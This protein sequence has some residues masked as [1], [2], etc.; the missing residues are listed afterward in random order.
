MSDLQT[1]KTAVLEDGVVDAEEVAKLQAAIFEDGTV[2]REEAEILFEI[3][4]K[5][6]GKANSPEWSTLFVKAI[7]AH[8]LADE[9]SPGV[10]DADEA[11]WL[12]SMIDRDGVVD[13]A[14]KA[15]LANLKSEVK[16]D[17]PEA[18]QTLFATHLN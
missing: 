18:L 8:V 10:V 6:S 9:A 15:L 7:S 2:D 5:V 12:K 1:L 4:D 3:N 16:G 13:E 14:E 11:A 17:I